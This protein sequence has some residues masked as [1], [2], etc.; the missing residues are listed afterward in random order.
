[1]ANH[2]SA[3]WSVSAGRLRYDHRSF[4]TRFVDMRRRVGTTG[5]LALVAEWDGISADIV[6][7]FAF[8]ELAV[9]PGFARHKPGDASLIARLVDEHE[10]LHQL[11]EVVTASIA[12][13]HVDPTIL[14]GFSAAM[15]S[16]ESIEC[17]RLYPWLELQDRGH[18]PGGRTLR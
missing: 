15:G 3:E 10:A 17:L 1:M 5:W 13:G 11:I 14:D 18:D 9:F 7:H 12:S 16:H 8:E 2:E 4:A 6:R